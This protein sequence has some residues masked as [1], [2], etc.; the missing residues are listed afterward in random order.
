MK[1]ASLCV[2][3][4]EMEMEMT[5]PVCSLLF[6]PRAV[7]VHTDAAHEDAGARRGYVSSLHV[8]G[9]ASV[10]SEFPVCSLSI[11]CCRIF[12]HWRAHVPR[13]RFP[14]NAASPAP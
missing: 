10:D 7:L 8:N 12:A 3:S 11:S 5:V 1:Q 14:L 9:A 2:C 4:V 6:F 13:E